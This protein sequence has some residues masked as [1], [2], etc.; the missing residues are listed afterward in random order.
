MT[1]GEPIE[2]RFE[3]ICAVSLAGLAI[4]CTFSLVEFG[5]SGNLKF[6]YSSKRENEMTDMSWMIVDMFHY[7]TLLRM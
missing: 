1:T 4:I 7:L 6:I 3:L 2:W 5:S